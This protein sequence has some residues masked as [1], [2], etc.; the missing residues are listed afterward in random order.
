[1]R[2]INVWAYHSDFGKLCID[3]RLTNGEKISYPEGNEKGQAGWHV[4]VKFGHLSELAKLLRDGLPMP[5]QFCGNWTDDCDPIARGEIVRLAIMVHGEQ[6]GQLLV[7]GRGYTPILT[8]DTIKS[9]HDD[10]HNIGLFTR[11]KVS[12]ILFMGCLAGQELQGT[13]L[14]KAL[15]QVW[16]GR[17]VVGFTTIGYRHPGSM[18]RSTEYCEEPGMRD[19]D[20]WSDLAA[21]PPKWDRLWS[22]FA[23]LPWASE[24]SRHAKVARNGV[25][26]VC[27]SDDKGCVEPPP[28][29]PPAPSLRKKVRKGS[30]MHQ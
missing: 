1:M 18:A 28:P 3:A 27:P 14:L 22:D 13:R 6:S 10:L 21:D 11:E 29:K 20:A 30:E 26:E 8:V 19:T 2:D 24:S 23:K 15:S 25:L 5:K 16:P 7:N 9:F 17:R 12:T 4:A